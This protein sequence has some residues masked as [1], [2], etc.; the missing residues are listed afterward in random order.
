M[1]RLER[2]EALS[3][4]QPSE[5]GEPE[6][7]ALATESASSVAELAVQEDRIERVRDNLLCSTS[8]RH[9]YES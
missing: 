6:V 9:G 5:S 3:K 1:R 2:Y 7:I 8:E 4:G